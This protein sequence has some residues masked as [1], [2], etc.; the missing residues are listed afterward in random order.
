MNYLPKFCMPRRVL[1][2]ILANLVFIPFAMATCPTT[3]ILNSPENV[4]S[5]TTVDCQQWRLGNLT[6]DS[7]VTLGSYSS[8]YDI[9]QAVSGPSIGVLTNNGTV[10]SGD[11]IAFFLNLMALL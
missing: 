4:I 10:L 6:I 8:P 11:G 1:V 3:P 5:A 9:I 2:V 7:G